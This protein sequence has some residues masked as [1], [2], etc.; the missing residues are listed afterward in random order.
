MQ[1][2][3]AK[4]ACGGPGATDENLRRQAWNIDAKGRGS[5]YEVNSRK[6]GVAFLFINTHERV[7]ARRD[8]WEAVG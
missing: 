7:V 4:W 6:S 1:L 3:P 5:L 2:S 8:E